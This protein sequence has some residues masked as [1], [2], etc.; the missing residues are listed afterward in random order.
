[1]S[2]LRPILKVEVFMKERGLTIPEIML[3]G[4]TRVA[5]GAGIG[6][7]LA[8]KLND[9]RRKGAGLALTVV[10]VLTTIPIVIGIIKKPER[11]KIAA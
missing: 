5:L 2:D 11:E 3:L 9:D 1:M 7:L 8:G 4:G 6:L 10:G